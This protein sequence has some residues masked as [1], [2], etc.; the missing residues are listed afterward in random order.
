MPHAADASGVA[1]SALDEDTACQ[2]RN[3]STPRSVLLWCRSPASADDKAK[4]QEVVDKMTEAFHNLS[5]DP[6]MVWFRDNLKHA[7]AVLILREWRAGFIL[8]GAGGSGVMMSRDAHGKWSYPAF[9]GLGAGSVGLQIGAET[10]EVALLIMTE[11]GRDALLTTEV[12]LGGDITVAA[13]PVG[14]GAK[15]AT[16]RVYGSSCGCRKDETHGLRAQRASG[17]MGDT[18]ADREAGC[19]ASH[20]QVQCNLWGS[21]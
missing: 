21:R 11:K 17:V 8:G 12:K 1:L 7:Q 9:Y 16:E 6:N 3:P 5:V 18:L 14:A 20:H 15:A 4:A 13:G 19:K 10:S 2:H